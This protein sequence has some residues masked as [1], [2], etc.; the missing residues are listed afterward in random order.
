MVD[1]KVKVDFADPNVKP[2]NGW[3]LVDNPGSPGVDRYVHFSSP[4]FVYE[5]H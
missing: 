1:T 5:N 4:I 2:K 3:L